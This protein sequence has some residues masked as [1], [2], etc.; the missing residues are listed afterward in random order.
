MQLENSFHV[1]APPERVFEYLLDVNKIVGCVPGAELTE[2]VDQTTFKGKVKV[3]LGLNITR[4]DLSRGLSNNDNTCTSPIYC[5]AYTPGVINLDSVDASGTI[6]RATF[7]R[8]AY[9][10]DPLVQVMNSNPVRVTVIMGKL[11]TEK[12]GNDKPGTDK[13]GTEKT[14]TEKTGSGAGVR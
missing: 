1:S 7:V 11:G 4:N 14:G 2:V 6:D 8:H 3:N 10:S 13:P 9:V 12:P 5:F